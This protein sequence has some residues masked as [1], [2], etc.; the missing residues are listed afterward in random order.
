MWSERTGRRLARVGLLRHP[1]YD[2][3][4][5]TPDRL[6]LHG[7]RPATAWANV[8]G[9]WE[10]KTALGW[11]HL[12][13]TDDRPVPA[14]HY[15]QVQWQM[16]VTGLDVVW[17]VALAGPRLVAH[18]VERDQPFMDDLATICERFWTHYVAKRIPPPAGGS[19]RLARALADRWTPDPDKT[20]VL[21]PAVFVPLRDRITAAKAIEKAAKADRLAAENELRLLLEDAEAAVIDGETVATWRA[22]ER[23]GY[24]VAAS[25]VRTLRLPTPKKGR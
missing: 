5:A 9:L 8:D 20:V 17:L 4:G 14:H 2:W 24:T 22:T 25:T 15:A 1:E 19:E 10:G 11:A 12:D 13:W 18:R 6:L 3:M 21:D 16:Q 23:A 7:D